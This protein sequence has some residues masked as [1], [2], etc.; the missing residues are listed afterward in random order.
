VSGGLAEAID[1]TV[2]ATNRLASGHTPDRFEEPQVVC[3]QQEAGKSPV[4]LHTSFG[5][6]APVPAP[7]PA[8]VPALVEAGASDPFEDLIPDS[9]VQKRRQMDAVLLGKPFPQLPQLRF[10][11]LSELRGP[12]GLAAGYRSIRAPLDYVNQVTTV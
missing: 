12:P 8:L 5:A 9:A 1:A 6:D 2:K 11:S 10:R 3:D 7:V 4:C